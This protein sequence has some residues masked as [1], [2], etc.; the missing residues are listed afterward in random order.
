[1]FGIYY[2]LWPWSLQPLAQVRL[3]SASVL[4]DCGLRTQITRD[5]RSVQVEW[6][7]KAEGCTVTVW[8]SAM[9]L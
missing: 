7:L 9:S 6:K 8:Q 1:M 4:S 5:L 3:Q 2:M